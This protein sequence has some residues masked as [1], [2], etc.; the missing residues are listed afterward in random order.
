MAR[1]T[2]ALITGPSA[3]GKS[4]LQK[5][6]INM[7][8]GKPANFTTRE[9]RSN[10]ELDEYVF[11]D[12]ATFAQKAAMGD[13]SEI[14]QYAGNLYAMTRFFDEDKKLAII[15]DP[16]GKAALEAFFTKAGRKYFT[17][18]IDCAEHVRLSRL[19]ER[20]TSVKGIKERMEDAEWM[21]KVNP[22]YDL[23]LDGEMNRMELA[24][25]V[26]LHESSKA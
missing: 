15:V 25:M 10:E 9:P 14:T 11:I 21:K 20:G 6:L 1:N 5:D 23:T 7:G 19:L 8:W 16:V 13:F 2:V 3:S 17:V 22:N 24:S 18:W 26:A 12:A 4:T